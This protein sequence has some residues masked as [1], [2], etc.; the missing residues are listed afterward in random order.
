MTE[1]DAPN[2]NTQLA[3]WV[4]Q[5]KNETKL[6]EPIVEGA[7]K[8]SNTQVG[9]AAPPDKRDVI[10]SSE[11]PTTTVTIFPHKKATAG[12]RKTLGWS[13]LIAM[14]ASPVVRKDNESLPL[15]KYS[16]LP[17]D[18]RAA[19]AAPDNITAIVG[20]Y[21]DGQVSIDAAAK[22][23][24]AAGISA[25]FYTTRRHHPERPRWRVVVQLS[26][27]ISCDALDQ[28]LDVLNGALGGI[29][30]P[31]SWE[32][33]RCY[34]YG[35]VDGNEYLFLESHGNPLDTRIAEGIDWEPKA[36]QRGQS[37]DPKTEKR[38]KA[39]SEERAFDRAVTIYQVNDRTIHD[40]SF[41]LEVIKD[42]ADD[43]GKWN[44]TFL[45]MMSF[46]GTTH[47]TPARALTEE[48]SQKHSE[49][50]CEKEDD[51]TKWDRDTSRDITHVSVFHWADQADK[52]NGIDGTPW[53]W[54]ARAEA[55]WRKLDGARD[56]GVN[57]FSYSDFTAALEPPY[58]VW[59]RVLQ[60][61]CLYALTAKWGHGKT[62]V[63]VTVAL[64][65]A[66][67]MHLGG[68]P[69]ERARVLYLCGENPEDVR[70]R[71]TAAALKFDVDGVELATQ[72]Y[73]TRRPVSLDDP[74]QLRHFVNEASAFGPFGLAVIDTGPAHSCA[75][76][77]NQNR[78]MHK[79]AMALRDLMS[80]IGN[81]ATVVLMHPTKSA[82]RDGLEPRGGG[83]FSGS[84]DGELCAWQEYGKIEF[85][86][87][88]KFRGPGFGSIWFDIEKYTL[89]GMVDN[90]GA[91][92]LTVLAVEASVAGRAKTGG[93][94]TG[95]AELAFRAL[96][97]LL[98][99]EDFVY[100]EDPAW[101]REA[102][103]ELG[104]VAPRRIDTVKNWRA[105]MDEERGTKIKPDAAR[106]AFQRAMKCLVDSDLVI[107]WREMCW[108]A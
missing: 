35:W 39:P 19:G 99:D 5:G 94:L 57:V 17:G 90:F 15:I 4:N 108:L 9:R 74:E 30:A 103:E 107:V 64:H 83:A 100:C 28:Y 65:V 88:T 49:K 36:K 31:E 98:E 38:I 53:C 45:A 60:K 20:D 76:E 58:Y 18:S 3:G 13:E 43:R 40:L 55:A 85:F 75:D 11:N 24:T 104:C 12:S 97:A 51:S 96:K 25:F 1:R 47:E 8:L 23:L 50:W 34:F 102:A 7:Q 70:L 101:A 71:A 21:D 91:P 89:P 52:T 84:I 22:L 41:A 69:T 68:H 66:I 26:C 93:G 46:K 32:S 78:E 54:R 27:P 6:T 59:H 44:E 14:H 86:H 37:E 77:E 29:L 81:P 61:G 105:K 42:R 79:L 33:T 16:A 48:W 56:V 62:A 73:F 72:I 106:K 82:D 95:G 63:M 87:R 67:G 2:E 92:V 80:P 10:S